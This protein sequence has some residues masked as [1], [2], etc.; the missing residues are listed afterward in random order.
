MAKK[1]IYIRTLL[2]TKLDSSAGRTNSGAN[3]NE[4]WGVG[5][6]H[7]LY[8]KDG[9]W[10]ERLERFPGAYFDAEGYILFKSESE[11]ISHPDLSIGVKVNIHGGI[12]SLLGYV[13]IR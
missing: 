9:H 12:S 1:R 10:Y 13:R 7:A 3:L 5:A 11:Y 6:R 2:P 4:K 8:H